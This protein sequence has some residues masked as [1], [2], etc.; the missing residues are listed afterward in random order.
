MKPSLSVLL[1]VHNA[2]DM[3]QASMQKLLDTLPELTSRF[4]VLIIDDGSTDATC[5]VAYELARDY[6]QVNVTSHATP[7]GW[8]AAVAKQARQASGEYLMIHC[9]GAVD[10]DEMVSLWRMRPPGSA[11][12][13][14]S[15]SAGFT[16]TPQ[17]KAWR[18]DSK[19]A[20]ATPPSAGKFQFTNLLDGKCIHA[21]APK[22]N[23]LLLRHGHLDRLE[24][25]LAAIPRPN[26]LELPGAK[27]VRGPL[28]AKSVADKAQALK[29]PSFLGRVRSFTLGE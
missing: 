12:E 25:S 15:T 6:P 9:G 10:A 19:A 26:W 8:A 11:T 20:N 14:A 24:H 1:S 22:S 29:P 7:L 28:G 16:L 23:F 2:Q 5:E 21:R 13:S 18:M 3:L 4:E 27:K 17:G